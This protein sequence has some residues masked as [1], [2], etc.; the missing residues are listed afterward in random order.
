VRTATGP[1]RR[2]ARVVSV[3][4]LRSNHIGKLG[5]RASLR[6]AA[7][8]G[9]GRSLGTVVRVRSAAGRAAAPETAGYARRCFLG[10]AAAGGRLWIVS[11][12]TASIERRHV[13]RHGDGQWHEFRCAFGFHCQHDV[14]RHH[15]LSTSGERGDPLS[16]LVIF[17]AGLRRRSRTPDRESL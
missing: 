10:T 14:F 15:S 9:H 3:F 1:F 11:A 6:Q 17:G 8:C 13:Y 16:P 5:G 2:L 12:H 4:A 7:A